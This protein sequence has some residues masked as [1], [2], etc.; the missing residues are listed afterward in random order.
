[1]ATDE[2]AELSRSR[3]AA[4]TRYQQGLIGRSS[5]A[6]R[7]AK[8]V[9]RQPIAVAVVSSRPPLFAQALG[10]APR[11]SL[12]GDGRSSL[13]A[14]CSGNS[15]LAPSISLSPLLQERFFKSTSAPLSRGRGA[16]VDARRARG[17]QALMKQNMRNHAPLPGR[18]A[19]CRT[20]Q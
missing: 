12:C 1:M 6:S 18:Q 15:L 19:A 7:I 14:S 20:S 5:I 2:A 16:D 17:H 3:E 11:A 13:L 9:A 10:I 4:T 8:R